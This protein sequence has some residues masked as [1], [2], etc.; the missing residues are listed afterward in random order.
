MSS[1]LQYPIPAGAQCACN[2]LLSHLHSIPPQPI[3]VH[4]VPFHSIPSRPQ[5]KRD[6]VNSTSTCR[7]LSTAAA[8]RGGEG[9]GG[10]SG[11]RGKDGVVVVVTSGKG[12]VG[13]TTTAASLAY[14]LGQ[15]G[16]CRQGVRIP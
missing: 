9:S 3:R 4:P 1:P 8:G 10:G 5:N 6:S 7:Q 11:G 16:T 15:V 12:G 2:T 14:G 13:K